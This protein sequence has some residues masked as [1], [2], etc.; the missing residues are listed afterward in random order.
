MRLPSVA[1]NATMLTA[2]V[3]IYRPA[4]RHAGCLRDAVDNGLG[5][6]LVEGHAAEARGVEGARH[7]AA[8]DERERHVPAPGR[9]QG[10]A[11]GGFLIGGQLI[12]KPQTVPAHEPNTRTTFRSRQA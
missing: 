7:R 8:L 1:I 12:V 3:G 11:V 9:E 6:D 5:L 4:K 2:S 10:A